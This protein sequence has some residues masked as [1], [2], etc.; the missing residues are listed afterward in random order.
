M[1]FK[2][3]NLDQ[4]LVVTRIANT[5]YFE[6]TKEYHTYNDS[7]NFCEL[8]YV[9]RGAIYVEAENYTG[10]LSNNQIIIHMP[11]E[12]HSLR[13]TDSVSP[14]VIVIGFECD[15]K[16]LKNFAKAPFKLQSAQKK[17]LSEI[18]KE[19]MNVFAPP[20]DVPFTMEM[21]KR[22]NAAFGSEQMLKIN[23]E[24]FLISIIRDF[25][26]N[27]TASDSYMPADSKISNVCDYINMHYSEKIV[28]DDI[29]FLFGMNK[30]SLCKKFKAEYGTTILNYITKLKINESKA[31][32][33]ANELSIT[34]IS[35]KL[36]F[37]SIHYFCRLFKKHTGLSP[38]EYSKTIKSK[39]NL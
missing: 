28:L 7:H 6:F 32:I 19:A 4:P 9:D 12:D 23:L 33:R 18:M 27:N 13:C 22:E 25:N 21:K 2:L 10:T 35:E 15:C 11:N 20:Y 5:H 30:T 3:Q 8:L 24:A 36:G 26:Q 17:M 29:C 39:L 1:D 38:K 37:N 31:Y 16:E 34:E 14:N